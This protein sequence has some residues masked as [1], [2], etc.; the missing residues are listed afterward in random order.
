MK[1]F[2]INFTLL[3]KNY[4]A[5]FYKS[6]EIK[7]LF[8]L[9]E[10][11]YGEQKKGEIAMFVGGCV[12]N[13][14]NK[15]KIDDIDIATIL[16]TD[17]IKQKLKNSNFNVIDTGVK[18]GSVTIVGKKKYELTT[19]RKDTKSDG[20]HA[21]I[22][23]IDD[24]KEDSNRRD[25]TIN[26]I[27]MSKNGKFFDPQNGIA[28]FKNK[29]VKFIG[30][31]QTRIQED[32]LRII[33]FIRFT[34]QYQSHIEET[35]IEAIKLN[36]NGI[37][38]IS[39]ERILS[40]LIKIINLQ[41]FYKINNSKNLK[42]IFSL[43]FPE[44]KYLNRINFTVSNEKVF[45]TNL[46]HKFALLTIDDSNNFEYFCHKYKTSNN[47]SERMRVI[48]IEYKNAK[49][50]NKYFEKNLGKKT[51]L[52]GKE[53]L[54]ILNLLLFSDKISTNN[55][56]YKKKYD[57]YNFINQEIEKN[58]IPNFPFDGNYLKQNGF[59]EGAS[60]GKTLKLL[61]AEWIAQDFKISEKRAFE[62]INNQ[63]RN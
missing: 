25:F 7:E 31:P 41:N 1:K 50:D 52:L 29:I 28:D 44:L 3:L 13:Y 36:L 32:F 12:R 19:L 49:K 53:I 22:E 61:E 40:E 51:Y 26:A 16:T 57:F 30:D 10:K 17:E 47:I 4:F 33:R 23:V 45:Y 62:I 6:L 18:H 9:L 14:L 27:Y 59:K 24:W 43:I 15:K 8:T 21:E 37:K 35:T 46:S 2:I 55:T 60:L 48:A 20:R 58:K 56:T 5:P 42:D 39:K 34:I 11:N 63:K 54:K 38:K